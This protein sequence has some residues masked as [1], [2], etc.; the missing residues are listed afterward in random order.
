MQV[1]HEANK[2]Y[3]IDSITAPMGITHYW[4]F[5][6]P[7]LDFKLE[8]FKYLE[9]TIGPVIKIRVQNLEIDIPTSWML[10]AVDKETYTVDTIPVTSCATFE[11][12]ILLFSPDDC[13][14]VTTRLT[15]IDYNKKQSCFHPLIQKGTAM[16][17]PTGPE[18][19]HRKQLFYGIVMGP[20]DLGKHIAG[21]T[22][23]DILN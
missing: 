21:K 18:F 5:N 10:L 14:L 22:V 20:H 7:M 9:E 12:D 19:S 16:I 13:K 4:S 23:G 8:K 3:I 1:L 17:H 15:V 6:A 11:H 2:S